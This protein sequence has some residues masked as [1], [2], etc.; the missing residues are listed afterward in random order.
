M[1]KKKPILSIEHVS[2]QYLLSTR[3]TIDALK[4]VNFEVHEGEFVSL[5]GP[6]GCGKSTLI[7]LLAGLLKPT[8][9][10]VLEYGKQIDGDS[11][12][13]GVVFQHYNLFPWLTVEDNIGFGLFIR[14]TAPD[15]RSQIVAHYIEAIGL[16]GFEKA[17]PKEL[18]GGMQQRVALG[19][20]FATNPKILLMDE[21]FA[22]LDVQTKRLMQDLFLQIL[23]Y[24]PRTVVFV[25][26]DVEEAVFLGDNVYILAPSP[27]TIR[28][29]V[30]V[31]L[32]RPRDLKTEFSQ[33]FIEI[34]RYVQ[35]VVTKES[36]GS[37]KLDLEIY[38]NL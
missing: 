6:S 24:E 21:P 7:K 20:A 10:R 1:L 26:H 38:K 31:N 16:K 27:G 22:A 17:Y 15:K 19:R 33:S 11:H 12:D 36:L 5:I 14:N 35:G 3:E 25:T 4:D 37:V 8:A 18:S 34:K 28:E 2:K 32:P 30:T 23:Q 13:R 29:K 9:G